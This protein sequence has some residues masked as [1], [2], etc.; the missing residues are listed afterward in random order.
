LKV[1]TDE[2]LPP[3]VTARLKE[4]GHD[5]AAVLEQGM[6]GWKDPALW[7]AVQK[8]GRFFVTSDKEFGDIRTYP[9]GTHAGVL[10]L[11]PDQDGIRP[12]VELADLVFSRTTLEDLARAV[13][14]VTPRG[15]R[16][17]KPR[18]AG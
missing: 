9:P 4:L 2:D 16:A 15:I 10:V 3:A 7:T 14:V 17:R 1:K 8:E 13:S 11:R 5:A 12:L 6:G 18:Q